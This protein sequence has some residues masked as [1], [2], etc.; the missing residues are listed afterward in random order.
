MLNHLR[1]S[2]IMPNCLGKKSEYPP[3][4]VLNITVAYIKPRAASCVTVF[5]SAMHVY[6]NIGPD[7]P[8]AALE[9]CL[10]VRNLR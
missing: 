5:F 4:N 9:I 6:G 2:I 8:S 1:I 7:T 3:R 10:A